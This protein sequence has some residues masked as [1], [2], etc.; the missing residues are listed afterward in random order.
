MGHNFYDP[1]PRGSAYILPTINMFPTMFWFPA[2]LMSIGLCSV[3]AKSSSSE[4]VGYP[5]FSKITDMFVL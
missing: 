5:G 2:F 3:S 1:I 4:P